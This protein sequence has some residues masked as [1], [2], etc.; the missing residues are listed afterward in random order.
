M[1]F[2]TVLTTAGGDDSMPDGDHVWF[3]SLKRQ[4]AGVWRLIA[5][6]SGA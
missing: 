6:G 5:G 2:S 4:L 3:Y 1:V